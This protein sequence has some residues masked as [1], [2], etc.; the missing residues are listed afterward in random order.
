MVRVPTN[1]EVSEEESD[2]EDSDASFK[3]TPDNWE[4]LL[5]DTTEKPEI[6]LPESIYTA[7]LLI[8]AAFNSEEYTCFTKDGRFNIFVNM[9]GETFSFGFLVK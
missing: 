5:V 7:C 2:V 8:P 6:A 3:D 9:Q 1:V 4:T